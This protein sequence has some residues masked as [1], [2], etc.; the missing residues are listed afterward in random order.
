FPGV[1]QAELE[2]DRLAA[3]QLAQPGDELQQFDGCAEGAVTGRRDTVAVARNAAHGGDLRSDLV[4]RQDAA[5]AGLGALAE[6]DLDHPH[7][8]LLRLGGEALRIECA[9]LGAAAEVAAAQLP[10]QVAA[11]LAVVRADAAFA[12]VVG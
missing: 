5:V 1:P 12:G 6:L 8:R 2:A 11:M 9:V 10:D 4:L 7:L 3:G